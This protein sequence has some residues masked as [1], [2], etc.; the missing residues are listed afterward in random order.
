MITPEERQLI[1]DTI[2]DLEDGISELQEKRDMMEW[3]L[4]RKHD[5]LKAWQTK[6]AALSGEAQPTT[7]PHKRAPRGANLKAILGLLL[8]PTSPRQ[9]LSTAALVDKTGLPFSSVQAAT[10]QGE[11]QG[12]IEQNENGFWRPKQVDPDQTAEMNG[13]VN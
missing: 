8:D 12:L 6:L 7:E 3:D 9:G 5:R 1:E 2:R 13:K 10:K 4:S 11:Q